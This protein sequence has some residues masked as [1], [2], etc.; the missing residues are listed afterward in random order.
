MRRSRGVEK[1]MEWREGRGA[2]RGLNLDMEIKKRKRSARSIPSWSR[3]KDT[4]GKAMGSVKR[5]RGDKD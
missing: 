4:A 5:G 3:I 2:G 1:R